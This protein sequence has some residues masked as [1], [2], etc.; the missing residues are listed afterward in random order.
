[1]IMPDSLVPRVQTQMLAGGF[2]RAMNPIG[3]LV[4]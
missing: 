2:R 1:M 4:F 3:L